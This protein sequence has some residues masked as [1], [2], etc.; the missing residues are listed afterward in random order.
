MR[1]GWLDFLSTA[2]VVEI[3]TVDHHT[4]CLG[5][6]WCLCSRYVHVWIEQRVRH[7][8][9]RDIKYLSL[10]QAAAPIPPAA[11]TPPAAKAPAVRD[12]AS[13]RYWAAGLNVDREVEQHR[14]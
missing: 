4:E 13:Q 5:H 2:E 12:S 8:F 1:P 7:L 6:D 11:P 9:D 3:H 14:I 10:S